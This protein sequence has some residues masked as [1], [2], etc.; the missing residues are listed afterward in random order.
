[1]LPPERLFLA[2]HL[3]AYDPKGVDV[4]CRGGRGTPQVLWRLVARRAHHGSGTAVGDFV[5]AHL[6]GASKVPQLA[7]AVLGH[8]HVAGLH[9]EVHQRGRVEVAQGGGQVQQA[10]VMIVLPSPF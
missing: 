8:K 2:P 6:N 10:T 5:F 9:V 4:A 1:M 7:P 3:P